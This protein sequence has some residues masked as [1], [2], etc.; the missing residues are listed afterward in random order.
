MRA[1]YGS[2]QVTKDNIN[3]NLD[4][5]IFVPHLIPLWSKLCLYSNYTDEEA[6]LGRVNSMPKF[7]QLVYDQTEIQTQV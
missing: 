3:G 1:H 2:L 6:G 7:P 4:L 5:D